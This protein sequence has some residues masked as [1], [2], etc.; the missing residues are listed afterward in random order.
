MDVNFSKIFRGRA[1]RGGKENFRQRGG[2]KIFRPVA[3]HG[4]TTM[5]CNAT[6]CGGTRNG[7]LHPWLGPGKYL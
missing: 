1:G 5:P 4:G 6:A 3:G 2:G 7:D